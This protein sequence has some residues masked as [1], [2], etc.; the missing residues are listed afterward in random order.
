MQGW[1]RIS[2]SAIY[3]TKIIWL[4][5]QYFTEK[6]WQ[7]WFMYIIKCI[8]NK[9]KLFMKTNPHNR[10]RRCSMCCLNCMFYWQE[11]ISAYTE[12]FR[13]RDC[14]RFF[15]C[16]SR[17]M[18]EQLHYNAHQQI[19]KLAV[20]QQTC[21]FQKMS[22]FTVFKQ[23]GSFFSRFAISLDKYCVK[24]QQIISFLADCSF[25]TD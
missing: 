9:P 4:Y 17:N 15:S 5:E 20:F 22:R 23:I 24:T 25:L 7:Y 19:S 12:W 14:D 3:C 16:R 18:F 11:S 2:W 21:S 13:G 1:Q 8:N 10:G 6:I